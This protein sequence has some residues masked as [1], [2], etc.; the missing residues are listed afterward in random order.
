[1]PDYRLGRLHGQFVV[2][3]EEDGRRRRYRLRTREPREAR[4]F[5]REFVKERERLERPETGLTVGEIWADYVAEKQAQGKSSVTRMADAW[6]R[7]ASHYA[8]LGALS[9]GGDTT[10]DYVRDR[11]ESGASDGTIHTELGYLRAAL[12]YSLKQNAP[13]VLL[14]PKPRPK[15]RF[16]TPS[17]ARR[18]IDAA[19]M[20]HVRLFIE[21]ALHTAG[22]PSSIL[23]L[24]WDRVEFKRGRISLDNPGRD[25]TAKGRATVPIGSERFKRLLQQAHSAAR[26]THVIEWAGKKVASV[27]KA[28]SRAAERAGL[29]GVTPYVLRHTAAVWLAEAGVPMSEISQYLGHTST[30]VTERIYAR[31]SPD[32]LRRASDAISTVLSGRG[33]PKARGKQRTKRAGAVNRKHKKARKR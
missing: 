7:L 24:T 8:D 25:R 33:E 19:Q 31:Y 30:S 15:S 28:I 21:L 2:V 27:K 22:R 20:P 32:Y 16:L 13:A 3:W 9:L 23:D 12:R 6:K 11:R 18:L 10:R 29:E 17:E 26:T 14:P 1:M 5:L 4:A